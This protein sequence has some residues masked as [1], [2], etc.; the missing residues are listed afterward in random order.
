MDVLR[1]N[2]AKPNAIDNEASPEKF[3]K[4]D[5]L[6]KAFGDVGRAFLKSNNITATFIGEDG[7][8]RLVYG[9]YK[10]VILVIKNDDLIVSTF[11]LTITKEIAYK[12][13]NLKET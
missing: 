1:G 12:V 6:P 10:S 2:A 13:K 9:S 7:L 11:H 3:V 8:A 5:F 4:I